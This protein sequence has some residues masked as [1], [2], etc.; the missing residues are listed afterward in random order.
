MC[1]HW[2]SDVHG[3]MGLASSGPTKGC[4]IGPAVKAITLQGITAVMEASEAAEKA[5]KDSPWN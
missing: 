5:W 4:R 3:V 2:S 1:V